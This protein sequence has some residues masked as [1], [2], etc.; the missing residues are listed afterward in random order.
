VILTPALEGLRV[1]LVDDERDTLEA[2]AMVLAAAG[3]EVRT[4]SSAS[5]AF[6]V[7][8]AW[9]PGVI[10]SDIGM[11]GED[12]YTLIRRLR[13]LPAE[14]GG[15]VPAVALT[16]YARVQDRVKVLAAGFQMHT[17]KP[18]EPAELVAVVASAAALEIKGA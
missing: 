18:I 4:A 12:G 2:L 1:L 8:S 7:L 11:P 10:V 14:R 9:Q 17:P 13:E 16:A 5:R 6:E 3:A 15:R